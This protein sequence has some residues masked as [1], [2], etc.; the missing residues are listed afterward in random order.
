MLLDQLTG[1]LHSSLDGVLLEAAPQAVVNLP[2]EEA[3]KTSKIV[4]EPRNPESDV[5]GRRSLATERVVS[6]DALRG[7]DMLWIIG[8]TE[9]LMG[10]GKVVHRPFFNKFLEQ[11]HHVPWQ[12]LH[13]YDVIWPLF[14]L[15]MGAAIPLAI[16]KRRAKGE[17]DRTL[18]LHAAWR[19][20]VMFCLGTITQGNLLLFD[21]SK[22][23]P[24]F[25]VLHGLAAGYLVAT[26][27]AVKVKPKWHA[28]IIAA[29]LLA[30]WAMVML[31]PVPG[32]G[33][34]VLTPQ[35][36][37][38]AYVDH[39]VLGHLSYGENTWF[40][41]YL[42]FGASVLLGVLAGQMLM[43]DFTPQSKMY[44]LLMAGAVSLALG[45]IWSV[46]FPVIKLMWT[47]SY[48]LI[49]GGVSFMAMALFYWIIDVLGYK[50]WAFGFIVI[51]INSIAVYVATEI[52]DFRLVGNIFVGNLLPLIG[53]WAELVEASAAFAVVWL[54]LYW[55]YRE[56]EFIRI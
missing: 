54:I 35:G 21:W 47:S 42:G 45:L 6:L 48:V 52:F 13:F 33:A 1:C 34:G 29:L 12:G 51:G 53:R 14:M 49:S 3:M 17:S 22:F 56:K 55:M 20:I 26:I 30:Y 46:S 40:L 2:Q 37:L 9:I 5:A 50:K 27:V 18:L 11:F 43:S 23:R 19:A 16:A 24:C 31:I 39:L 7:F 10:L 36:N 44:R 4:T 41:S 8:G 15:I 38:P 25:S 32:V 28:A